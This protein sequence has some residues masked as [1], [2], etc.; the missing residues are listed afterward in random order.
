M[1]PKHPQHIEAGHR[2][3]F[4][5]FPESR[6][7]SPRRARPRVTGAALL[8]LSL[9][10]GPAGCG[11][12][13]DVPPADIASAADMASAADIASGTDGG[14]IGRSL[15]VD[16]DDGTF[17]PLVL[18]FG[19]NDNPAQADKAYTVEVRDKQ[20][21][22]IAPMAPAGP[23]LTGFLDLPAAD[24][25]IASDLDVAWTFPI[26]GDLAKL[27]GGQA[28]ATAIAGYY[29]RGG[30]RN[31]MG[32]WTGGLF[33][34][35]WFGFVW[36][37]GQRLSAI[38]QGQTNLQSEPFVATQRV[39][40]RVEKRGTTLRLFASYDGQGFHQVGRDVAL[41]LNPGGSAAVAITHLR[42]LD[43]SGAAIDVTADA[44]AWRW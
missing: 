32:D 35:Y 38:R 10:L 33:G 25:P 6:P 17:G 23:R 1:H 29:I 13:G 31:G 44:L 22:Y 8:G 9:L 2:S 12:D 26:A 37:G 4:P 41:V 27:G 28:T 34:D 24:V 40:Y 39:E 20:A 16:F 7:V 11:D 5:T 15:L 14:M 42:V 19:P 43:T 21:H 36:S 3:L 30:I 18:S